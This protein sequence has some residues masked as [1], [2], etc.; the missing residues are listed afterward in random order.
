M[1]KFN[2]YLSWTP[3]TTPKISAT[4]APGSCLISTEVQKKKQFSSK[5]DDTLRRFMLNIN[6][7]TLF[8]ENT[9]QIIKDISL[10]N[11]DGDQCFILSSLHLRQIF[12]GDVNQC[13]QHLQ[14][15]LV[16]FLHHRLIVLRDV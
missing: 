1:R 3:R 11:V 13:V 14:E 10:V 9:Y 4:H 2:F 8:S 12:N 15:V 16:G 5:M 7:S 6:I